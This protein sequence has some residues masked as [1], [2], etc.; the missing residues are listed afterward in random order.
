MKI[1]QIFFNF[2]DS[3]SKNLGNFASTFYIFIVFFTSYEVLMRYVFNDPTDW[4]FETCIYLSGSAICMAG[5]FVTQQQAHISITTI[6]DQLPKK[7]R[8]AIQIF[9]ITFACIVCF[10]LCYACLPWG[11]AAL[12]NWE[13][14]GTGLDSPGPGIVKPMIGAAAFLM[15]MQFIVNLYKHITKMKSQS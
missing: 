13:T 6:L 12:L 8:N 14:S 5:P 10:I 7:L 4:V 15:G 9:N 1:F 2:I 3:V 11:W